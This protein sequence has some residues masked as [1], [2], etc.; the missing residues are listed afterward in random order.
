VKDKLAFFDTALL[1]TSGL[2]LGIV[3]VLEMYPQY[4]ILNSSNLIEMGILAKTPFQ[5]TVIT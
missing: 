4:F 3:T 1:T 5:T 2:C